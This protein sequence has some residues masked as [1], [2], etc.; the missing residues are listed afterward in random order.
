M[1]VL[2]KMSENYKFLL[3]KHFGFSLQGT[4]IYSVVQ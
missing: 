3:N 4:R 2:L 1:N